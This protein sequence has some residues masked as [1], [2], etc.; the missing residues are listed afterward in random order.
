MSNT[1][2]VNS[3]KQSKAENFINRC[4]KLYDIVINKKTFFLLFR[5]WISSPDASFYFILIMKIFFYLHN[6]NS[7]I[8]LINM[9]I[10]KIYPDISAIFSYHALLEFVVPYTQV[11]PICCSVGIHKKKWLKY[12]VWYDRDILAA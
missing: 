2:K 8:S 4:K 3:H 10:I 1:D 6:S 5:L 9:K 7:M 12:L 11:H